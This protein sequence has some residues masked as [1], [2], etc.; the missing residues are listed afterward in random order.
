[1]S[2]ARRN[3]LE[4]SSTSSALLDATEQIMLEEGYAAVSSRHIAS[5]AG[6]TAA[7]VHYYFGTMDEL[8]IAVFRRIA[9]RSLQRQARVLSSS[10]PLWGLWESTRDQINT[11]LLMEFNALANHHKAV[12]AEIAIYSKKFR[13]MQIEIVS[14]VLERYGID[15]TR[16]PPATIILLMTGISRFMMIEEAFNVDIGHAETIAVVERHIRELEGDR[17]PTAEE[18]LAR[19]SS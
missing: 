19:F 4:D 10:Q 17:R 12:Q 7:L 8:F 6:V 16:W 13:R 11:A 3:R 1:M 2:P 14:T 15:P 18:Y 9:E 5:R